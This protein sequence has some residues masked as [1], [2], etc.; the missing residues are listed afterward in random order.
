MVNIY[1]Y[2]SVDW[3]ATAQN[4]R[5]LMR[6]IVSEQVLADALGVTKRTVQNWCRNRAHPSIDN[7]VL[8]AQFYGVDM[9]DILV[10]KGQR[11]G[12]LEE[13]DWREAARLADAARE[14]AGAD[15]AAYECATEEAFRELVL[16][17]AYW[18]QQ[19]PV[20][21]LDEFLLFMPLFSMDDFC[22]FL[23]CARENWGTNL[24]YLMEKIKFLYSGIQNLEAKKFAEEYRYFYLEYPVMP[25][26]GGEPLD[27]A[28]RRKQDAWNQWRFQKENQAYRAYKKQYEAFRQE[29]QFMQWAKSR[30]AGIEDAARPRK[31]APPV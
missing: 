3:E 29:L 10:T 2:F 15:A 22:G 17:Q 12:K 23:D 25:L 24:K 11:Q 6:G 7:L 16:L 1:D 31:A 21:D 5:G 9:L 18:R 4:L 14:K 20:G 26:L 19:W 30:I 13:E 27:E 8:L 28:A